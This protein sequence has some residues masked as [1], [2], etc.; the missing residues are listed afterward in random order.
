MHKASISLSAYFK[1]VAHAFH[2]DPPGHRW[3]KLAG[4]QSAVS[5]AIE[6][7]GEL[8]AIEKV[9]QR[10]AIFGIADFDAESREPPIVALAD[11][12]YLA[13]V[14]RLQIWQCI[15][16]RHAGDAGYENRKRR[17]RRGPD[18]LKAERVREGGY[19]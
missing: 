16:P 2:I 6:D 15:V 5:G 10:L 8:I 14:S 1:Q 3:I 11:A 13:R 19:A 7:S 12:D 9:L 18:H 17:R 4:L